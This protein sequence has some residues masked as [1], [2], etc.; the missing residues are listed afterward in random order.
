MRR[1][2]SPRLHGGK[3]ARPA[4]AGQ[5][6][7]LR[8][9]RFPGAWRLAF[10]F[11]LC[12]TAWTHAKPSAA[13]DGGT[14]HLRI[15]NATAEPVRCVALLAHFVTRDLPVVA[16]GSALGLA[17]ERDVREGTLALRSREGAPM[18]LENILCGMDAGW[19][20]APGRVPLL[21]MRGDNARH[22]VVRCGI[23]DGG[24]LSCERRSAPPTSA[25]CPHRR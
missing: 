22:H 6:A 21:G 13:D 3:S 23:R 4:P 20:A 2:P 24:G 7:A 18:M 19:S 9:A 17:V 25:P 14:V 12:L 1:Q 10:A 5:T 16:P 11:A 8:P 15:E